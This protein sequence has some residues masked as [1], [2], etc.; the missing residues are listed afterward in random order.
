MPFAICHLRQTS[1]RTLAFH[2]NRRRVRVTAL[3]GRF[4]DAGEQALQNALVDAFSCI[5]E[6]GFTAFL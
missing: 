5:P 1:P 2:R 3:R 6:D 4:A